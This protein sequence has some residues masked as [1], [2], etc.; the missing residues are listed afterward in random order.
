VAGDAVLRE[1]VQEEAGL[2]DPAALVTLTDFGAVAGQGT[3]EK[4]KAGL[5][6]ATVG[7][8]LRAALFQRLEYGEDRLARRGILEAFVAEAQREQEAHRLEHP[9]HRG[10]GLIAGPSRR[11]KG[12]GHD[13]RQREAPRDNRYHDSLYLPHSRLGRIPCAKRSNHSSGS[14]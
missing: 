5:P 3:A 6:A 2:R 12:E 13:G 7:F 1:L 8:E 11:D 9:F 4:R 10:R 14:T